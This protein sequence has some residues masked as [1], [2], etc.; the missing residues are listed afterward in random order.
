MQTKALRTVYMFRQRTVNVLLDQK[1]QFAPR[2]SF[3][4]LMGCLQYTYKTRT[5]NFSVNVYIS[6]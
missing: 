4:L 2:L 6:F 5:L 1:V 3:N